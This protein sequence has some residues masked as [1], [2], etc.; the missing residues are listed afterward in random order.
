M[1]AGC[2]KDYTKGEVNAKNFIAVIT[3][4]KDSV[5][6]QGTGRVLE[7]TNEDRVFINFVDHGGTGLIA[8]PN[9]PYLYKD[10]LHQA[11]QKP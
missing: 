4:D 11:L 2:V 7:S 8:M 1:Y 6:G 9:P 3:G 10:K 5:Q